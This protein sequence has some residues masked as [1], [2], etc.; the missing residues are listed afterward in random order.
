MEA[1]MPE[2][3]CITL[4]GGFLAGGFGLILFFIQRW[5]E[6]QDK[7]QNLLFRLYQLIERNID[8]A[9]AGAISEKRRKWNE[10]KSISFLLKDT[11]IARKTYKFA[12]KKIQDSTD[13]DIILKEISSKL[14][15]KLIKEIHSN[16]YKQD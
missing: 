5:K 1:E 16:S 12:Q 7:E 6:K 11:N 13:K 2:N 15:K 3:F 8:N 14:N 4:L 10:I 9:E